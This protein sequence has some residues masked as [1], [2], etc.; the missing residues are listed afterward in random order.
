MGSDAHVIVVGGEPALINRAVERISDLEQRWS[1]FRDDSEISE[2]NRNAGT[3]VPVS[4]E[5]VILI[6]RA[7][8]PWRAG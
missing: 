8:P 5:T 1:R 4:S 3:F 7:T 2:L 6:Q